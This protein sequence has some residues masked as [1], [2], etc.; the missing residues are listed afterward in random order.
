MCP[1]K[2]LSFSLTVPDVANTVQSSL[3][4][5]TS[6]LSSF[7]QTHTWH[8]RQAGLPC[9]GTQY[10]L[11]TGSRYIACCK[12]NNKQDANTGVGIACLCCCWAGHAPL[13]SCILFQT[14][15]SR[16]LALKSSHDA[17]LM[18]HDCCHSW[19][20]LNNGDCNCLDL[21]GEHLS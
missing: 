3:Y 8:P 19:C 16:W 11:T 9:L 5:L 7:N 21:D 6:L 12:N 15:S 20:H 18:R 1:L 4:W 14:V 13:C 17:T 10:F 2:L